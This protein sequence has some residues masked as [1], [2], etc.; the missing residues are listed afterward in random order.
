M[1]NQEK[2]NTFGLAPA[3]IAAQLRLVNQDVS[4]GKLKTDAQ[5]LSVRTAGHFTAVEQFDTAIVAVRDNTPIYFWQVGE[6]KDTIKDITSTARYDGQP[7]VGIAVGKQSGG[8]AV[9]VAVA[10]KQ[11]LEQLQEK[12]PVGMELHLVRDDAAR[13]SESIAEVWFDLII[14]SI[15]AVAIVFW[16]LGDFCTAGEN[17]SA[18]RL[19]GR[20]GRCQ[21]RYG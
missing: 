8:N 9:K 21:Q 18:G 17:G 7:A 13:V 3:E 15:F 14:G 5:Q 20:S 11:E 1:L 2:L 12:L 6:V 10:V 19:Q 16:F 4:A